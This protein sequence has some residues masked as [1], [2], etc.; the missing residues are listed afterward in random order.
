LEASIITSGALEALRQ[1]LRL[2]VY[3]KALVA[4]E[5]TKSIELDPDHTLDTTGWVSSYKERIASTPEMMSPI[6][7]GSDIS[8]VPTALMAD[9]GLSLSQATLEGYAKSITAEGYEGEEVSDWTVQT[10]A[11]GSNFRESI[12]DDDGSV[13]VA[14]FSYPVRKKGH[15]VFQQP[16]FAGVWNIKPQASIIQDVLKLLKV[17]LS[18]LESRDAFILVWTHPDAPDIVKIHVTEENV[19]ERLAQ[20]KETC[21]YE[22][23]LMGQ[24]KTPNAYFLQKLIHAEFQNS[25]RLELRCKGCQESH[26]H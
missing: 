13:G 14:D 11:F 21:G 18:G 16:L 15:S 5:D 24:G 6:F 2:F 4:S 9:L 23:Q 7:G 25:Q 26:A 12:S 8:A 3:P 1:N 20:W 10:A 22:P 19:A 17:P